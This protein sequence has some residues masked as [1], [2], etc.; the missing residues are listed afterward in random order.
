MNVID[1][2]N[3][4][5]GSVD[6]RR[7]NVISV[8]RYVGHIAS[9]YFS[10]KSGKKKTDQSKG[11]QVESKTKWLATADS[12]QPDQCLFTHKRDWKLN[13]TQSTSSIPCVFGNFTP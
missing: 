1:V 6:F 10:K 3:Y 2:A 12:D 7:Q 13:Q 4:M 9:V 5:K 8:A 11:K